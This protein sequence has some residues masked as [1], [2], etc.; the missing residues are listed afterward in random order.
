[1]SLETLETLTNRYRIESHTLESFGHLIAGGTSGAIALFLLYPIEQLNTRSA[2]KSAARIITPH[3][4]MDDLIHLRCE[5]I[6]DIYR[7]LSFGI[8][9]KFCFLGVYFFFYSYLK[10]DWKRRYGV[11]LGLDEMPMA[12]AL[13]R[14]CIA[15]IL[16]QIFTSPLSTIQRILQTSHPEDSR[17]ASASNIIR[18]VSIKHGFR[19]LWSGFGMSMILVINPAINMY[20]YELFTDY[21]TAIVGH[22]SCFIDFAAGLL[23]KSIATMICYPLIYIK[24]N[25]QADNAAHTDSKRSVKDIVVNTWKH[26]GMEGFYKGIKVKLVLSSLND[27]LMFMIKE[28]V[29]IYTFAMMLYFMIPAET[30]RNEVDADLDVLHKLVVTAAV[31]LFFVLN[32]VGICY[33]YSRYYRNKTLLAEDVNTVCGESGEVDDEEAVSERQSL[34]LAL[35]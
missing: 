35:T 21:M 19:A 17:N 18:N 8:I 34:M 16:T 11:K 33:A 27:A 6:S 4:I 32:V 25:Q 22:D 3:S 2:I 26:D 31:A 7:G 24:Y 10:N 14:G 15:G 12:V 20:G 13:F 23:S 29:I 1:M 28:K 30:M 5:N 9:E